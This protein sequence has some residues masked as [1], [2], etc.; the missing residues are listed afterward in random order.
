M[1]K[2]D[3]FKIKDMTISG[4]KCFREEKRFELGDIT[5]I[6]GDNR[7]GKTSIG[8]AI[9]FALCGKLYNGSSAMDRLYSDGEKNLQVS[10]HLIGPDG[11]SINLIRARTDDKVTITCNGYNIRQ[12]DMEVLFGESEVFL[13]ILNP[14]Y[15]IEHL[16]NDGRT[17]LQKYLP[18]IAHETVLGQLSEHHQTLLADQSL[19]SP[20][21][22][23]AHQRE[24]MKE[25]RDGLIALN[26]QKAL[27]YRQKQNGMQDLA[28]L[29]RRNDSLTQQVAALRE[30]REQGAYLPELRQ[31]YTDLLLRID[32]ITA[33]QKNEGQQSHESRLAQLA[34]NL[35]RA[36]DAL[37]ATACKSYTSKYADE[38]AKLQN[39]LQ[40]AREDYRRKEAALY[41]LRTGVQCPVCSRPITEEA[42]EETRSGIERN[43][44][45]LTA[46]G[47]EK[48]TQLTQL[49]V[50]DQKARE[51]FDQ[52]KTEDTEKQHR[53]IARYQEERNNLLTAST[54]SAAN[55]AIQLQQ[56]T[57]LEDAL[58]LGGLTA[59]EK[60]S[61]DTLELD[62]QK[63][64]SDYEAMKA[65]LDRP[66]PNIDDK[67]DE[68][69]ELIKEKEALITAAMDY[70]SVRSELTFRGLPL[71]KVGFS[72]YDIMKTTGEVKNTFHFTYNGRD[73]WKLSHSERILAGMEVSELMQVL[74]GRNYPVF[75]DDS[76]SVVTLEKRPTGQVFLSRVVAGAPLNVVYKDMQP[77]Q[78]LKKA[79]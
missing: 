42:L 19:L 37:E 4:F 16:S 66:A 7:V 76:E 11:S 30:K 22:F 78:E 20:E 46:Q 56:R 23:I 60:L 64:E 55:L 39:E 75:V 41:N 44:Q 69:G 28:I 21:T 52:W 63:V 51:V 1:E 62:L 58:E 54:D 71:N 13:S 35:Q 25:Y 5:Y 27:L 49:R 70:L 38:M 59:E 79:G 72:L 74:T 2:I 50:M 9:A 31:Q 14:T 18:L 15:F 73:Y 53:Q 26:G 12:K 10:L 3:S 57:T 34:L 8:D 33:D 43:M 61:L 77:I 48:N 29:K 68:L 45:A 40:L 65:I 32:E 17:L 24:S 6:T 47:M 36:S 67:I